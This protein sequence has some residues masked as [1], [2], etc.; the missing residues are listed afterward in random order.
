MAAGQQLRQSR[1]GDW[2]PRSVDAGTVIDAYD[3]DDP[4]GFIDAV[5]HPVRAAHY[6]HSP[7]PARSVSCWA[8][9]R[10]VQLFAR[11]KAER[12]ACRARSWS[13][14]RARKSSTREL[15]PSLANT[16]LR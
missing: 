12:L 10:P 14:G 16:L 9:G 11:A 2:H 4:L 13:L 15:M 3:A 5:D 8:L 1:I 6:M 7:W